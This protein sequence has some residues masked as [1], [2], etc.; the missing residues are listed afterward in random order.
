MIIYK[1]HHRMP[2]TNAECHLSGGEMCVKPSLHRLAWPAGQSK[3]QA[4]ENPTRHAT[5]SA[6]KAAAPRASQGQGWG[7]EALPLR[8]D[9]DKLPALVSSDLHISEVLVG[10]PCLSF[11]ILLVRFS[12]SPLDNLV[13][14]W[15]FFVLS[16]S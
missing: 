16:N 11:I 4:K 14:G 3:K 9:R 2:D 5:P 7:P 10:M 15:L 13:K 1:R 12:F 6:L 8:S